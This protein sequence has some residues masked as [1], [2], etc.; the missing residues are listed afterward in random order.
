MDGLTVRRYILRGIV[1]GA[2]GIFLIGCSTPVNI[3]AD[4]LAALGVVDGAMYWEAQQKLAQEGYRCF[5]NGAKRENFDCTRTVGF[6]PT[7]VMRVT[8]VADDRNLVSRLNVP[9]PACMGTP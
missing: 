6:F 7:C 3:T 5:V 4:R 9:H 1:V 2:A 8:F